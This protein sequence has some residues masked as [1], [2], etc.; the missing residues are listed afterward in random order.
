MSTSESC[1][2]L[3]AQGKHIL[4]TQRELSSQRE[5]T[6]LTFVHRVNLLIYC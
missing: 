5:Q 4:Q 1:T 6:T 3:S 2:H